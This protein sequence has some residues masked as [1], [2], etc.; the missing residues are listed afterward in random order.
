MYFELF[1]LAKNSNQ[2]NPHERS[3]F[4]PNAIFDLVDDD[5]S[6]GITLD[7]WIVAIFEKNLLQMFAFEESKVY[8]TRHEFQVIMGTY[9]FTQYEAN[10]VFQEID[11]NGNEGLEVDELIQYQARMFDNVRT[12]SASEFVLVLLQVVF[13][14]V[15]TLKICMIAF[16]PLEILADVMEILVC[17][18]IGVTF[19]QLWY[20]D[21][22]EKKKVYDALLKMSSSKKDITILIEDDII[23]NNKTK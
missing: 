18:L 21:Y 9:G 6:G 16:H 10:C 15:A 8:F 12:M 3:K 17:F 23:E 1:K 19:I 2:V 5:G 7:E 11:L 14:I 22:N 20:H 13:A 4:L